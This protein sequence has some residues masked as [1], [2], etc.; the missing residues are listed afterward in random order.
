MHNDQHSQ[1]NNLQQKNLPDTDSHVY[2]SNYY[3]VRVVTV[4]NMTD[5]TGQINYMQKKLSL[6][7]S[8]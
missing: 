7:D 6:K 4:F 2:S 5:I 1:H 3:S 8:H